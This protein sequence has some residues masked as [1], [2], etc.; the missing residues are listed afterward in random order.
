M[1]EAQA[2]DRFEKMACV[3]WADLS[4]AHLFWRVLSATVNRLSDGKE[5]T[6]SAGQLAKSL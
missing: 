1:R 6:V 5:L 3:H 4:T 2:S